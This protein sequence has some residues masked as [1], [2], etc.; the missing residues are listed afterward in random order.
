M[1]RQGC[2]AVIPALGRA[3]ASLDCIVNLNL[4][5]ATSQILPWATLYVCVSVKVVCTVWSHLHRIKCR[6]MAP[7]RQEWMGLLG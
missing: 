2:V 1:S 4:A 3:E 6:L 7:C 5:W